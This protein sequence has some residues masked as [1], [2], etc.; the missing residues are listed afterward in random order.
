MKRLRAVST[1]PHTIS[2]IFRNR[3]LPRAT[4]KKLLGNFFV[5]TGKLKEC[6]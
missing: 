1:M 5:A 6:V 4:T 3:N 2:Y